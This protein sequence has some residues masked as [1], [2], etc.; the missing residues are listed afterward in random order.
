M[1]KVR[2]GVH[3]APQAV[4]IRICIR[5]VVCPTVA[6]DGRCRRRWSGGARSRPRPANRCVCAR[7][8]SGGIPR[9]QPGNGKL[10]GSCHIMISY[11]STVAH[12]ASRSMSSRSAP[13]PSVTVMI[14]PAADEITTRDGRPLAQVGTRHT[15]QID[16]GF[17]CEVKSL[18]W[19]RLQ[20]LQDATA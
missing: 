6:G 12:P 9:T 14:R 5:S 1:P 4:Y 3:R 2:R 7:D 13:S 11:S 20:G 16:R 19:Q 15:S 10:T 18:Q 8:N 17:V